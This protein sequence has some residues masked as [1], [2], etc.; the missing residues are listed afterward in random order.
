MLKNNFEKTLRN[1]RLED[2]LW[3][4]GTWRQKEIEGGLGYK[5]SSLLR[6]GI[7]S[8]ETD[9]VLID[10]R[11]IEIDRL[12]NELSAIDDTCALVLK[13]KYCNN[14]SVIAFSKTTLN[15][16]LRIAKMFL[17]ARLN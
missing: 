5:S 6:Q 3:E 8:H 15:F 7:K 12:I 9:Y 13:K 16:Y 17:V 4:W 14:S 1:K 2:R 10:E 11:A